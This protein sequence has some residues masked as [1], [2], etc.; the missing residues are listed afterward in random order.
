[1][2]GWPGGK[3]TKEGCFVSSSMTTVPVEGILASVATWFGA[4]P[5]RAHRPSGIPV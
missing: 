5:M 3:P 2:G 4:R 1:M